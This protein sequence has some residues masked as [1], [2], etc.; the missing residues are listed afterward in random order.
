M[1]ALG[2]PRA[3][4]RSLTLVFP[5]TSSQQGAKYAT[6][7]LQIGLPALRDALGPGGFPDGIVETWIH[8]SVHGR[9]FPW[10]A[11][12]RTER[13]FAGFEEG[14]AEGITRLVSRWVGFVPGLPSYGRYVQTYEV[15]ADLIGISP[16]AMYRRLYTLVNGSVMNGFANEID[17]LRSE[18][19]RPPLT[20]E[21]RDRLENTAKQV[22]AR[23]H[24]SDPASSLLGGRIRQAWR[25]AL[26]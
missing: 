12:A 4:V 24:L 26:T 19:G 11:N 15:L 6:C 20:V 22:F 5:P 3:P 8:E 7:D 16:E 13:P 23:A 9:Q 2:F 1:G 17:T 21:Q 18:T 14:L 10:G 25:R